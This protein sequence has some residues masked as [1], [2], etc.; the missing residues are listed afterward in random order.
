MRQQKLYQQMLIA[1]L[2]VNKLFS[3]CTY[4]K[5]ESVCFFLPKTK[6]QNICDYLTESAID[7]L[8]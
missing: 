4:S 5:T 6:A 2:E 8:D 1:L 7:R 3:L